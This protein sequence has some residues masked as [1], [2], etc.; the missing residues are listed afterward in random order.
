MD[1]KMVSYLSEL[2][3][4]SFSDEELEKIA[5]DMTS[6]IKIMDTIKEIDVTYDALADNHDVYLNDLREDVSAPSMETNKILQNAVS[7]NN[8]FVVPKVVE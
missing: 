8:C 6:I 1:L 7:S 5:C 2:G 4:L 3:K